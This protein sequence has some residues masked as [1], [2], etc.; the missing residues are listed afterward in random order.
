MIIHGII[1]AAPG[2]YYYNNNL[3]WL[4]I[5]IHINAQAWTYTSE[6]EEPACA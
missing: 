5:L 2:F 4:A 6:L 3:F 1:F